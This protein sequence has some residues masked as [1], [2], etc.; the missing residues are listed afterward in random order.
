MAGVSSFGN[1]GI[2]P[3]LTVFRGLSAAG[4]PPCVFLQGTTTPLDGGEG[5]YAV[6]LTDK[7][8]ADNGTNII[9]DG[10]GYRWFLVSDSTVA[11]IVA[12]LTYNGTLPGIDPLT[13]A[14]AA[15][16]AAATTDLSTATGTA[17][18]ITG[19][20]VSISAL[21]TLG[22][23]RLRILTFGDINTLVYNAT[24]LILPGGANI[25]TA[26][27]D[28]AGFI[29]LGGGNWQCIWY[30]EAS[31]GTPGTLPISE[32]GTGKTTSVTA[33]DALAAQ[34]ANITAASTT[35]LASA[36]GPIVNV[37]GNT[38]ITALGTATAGVMRWVKFTGT[39]LLTYNATSLI[40]PGSA[41]ITAAANDFALFVSLG[42]GNWICVQYFL[43]TGA[44]AV[45]LP[46]SGGGTGQTTSVAAFDAL[47]AAGANIASATTTDIG[48]ATGP[49]V[50]VTGA[51]TITGLGAKTAG[52]LRWVTFS[53][54]PLLTYNATSLIL[55][56]AANIQAAA[57][58]TALFESLGSGNW[59]CLFYQKAAGGITGTVAIAN[60]GTGQVTS[61]AAFNALQ[62]KGADIT[63]ASTTDLSTAT[64]PF[65]NVTGN[66][67]ITAFGTVAA[68][69]RVLVRF[70]G[71][72]L[73]TYNATSVILPTSAN[74]QTAAGDVALLESLGSGNWRCLLYQ[75]FA[76]TPL[77]L[78]T[79]AQVQ[80]QSVATSVLTPA[81]LAQKA[82]FKANLNGSNQTGIADSTFTKVTFSNALTNVGSYYDAA[83]NY[84]WTPPASNV[85]IQATVA[86]TTAVVAASLA[87]CVIYKNGAL[88]AYG[89][90]PYAT[91]AADTRCHVSVTDAANGTDYYE[92][93]VYIDSV[94]GGAVVSGSVTGTWFEGWQL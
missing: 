12:E 60:G 38:T 26:A 53:G 71:T 90:P 63:A 9:V 32:G 48:A 92:C 89:T 74:I 80:A 81:S 66:T 65:I 94:A 59:Q 93:F 19:S 88:F 85:V 22:A 75:R 34:G 56:G 30:T 82:Y 24:S 50:I 62:A 5:L 79:A 3:T 2:V 40:L 72:P 41:N 46:I 76:G 77:S 47:A 44:L 7:T 54:A 20:S 35:N 29:S 86:M 25:T 58:D 83:T 64:G 10:G 39:P 8:S 61:V 68:G 6:S 70:T 67:T 84:R 28:V 87:V 57:N 73:L 36:T 52:T 16:A 31:G 27:N 91:V 45:T 14:G 1:V 49:V 21:G 37:T 42:S 43:A 11:Q 18:S 4:L 55:P 33:F 17:V 78:A 13:A 23:G 15:I 51:V 69:T